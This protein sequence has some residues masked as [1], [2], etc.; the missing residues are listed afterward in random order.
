MDPTKLGDG[1]A[2]LSQDILGYL[3]F[4]AGA[5]DARFLKNLGDLFGR[6]AAACVA[7]E[8]AWKALAERLR[9]ELRSV[10]GTVEA[11]R[12][13]EQAEAVLHLV[14]DLALPAYREHHCD[15]L[16]HQSEEGLFQPLWIGRMCEAV[17]QQ[18]GPWQ[19]SDRI[20][21]AAI[22]QLNDY[23]GHRPVA[24]L[25]TEQKIQPYEHE[26]VR[27][28]PLWIRG[29]GAA[30]GP[31]RELVETAVAIL[32]ATD[33]NLLFESL[34]ALEELDELAF[35]PRAY[36][37]DSPVNKRPNYIFGQWD[38]HTLDNAGHCRRFVLQQVTLD[39]MLDRLAEHGQLDHQQVLF[40]EAAVLAGTMLMGSGVSGNRPDAHDSTVTLATLIEKIAR[41]R[42]AF[43]A[44]LLERMSDRHAERLRAEA[45]ALRQPFGGARQHFNHFLAQRRAQQLQHVHVAQVFAAIGFTAAAA[46]HVAVVPVASARMTCEM[47]C[48]L[49]AAHL[50]VEHEKLAEAAMHLPIIEKLLYTAI[51]C[52]AMVDPWNILGFGGQYSLFPAIENSIHDHRVDELLDMMGDIFMLSVRIHRAAA[53]GGHNEL[54]TSLSEGL[55]ALATWWDKFAAGELD[56]VEGISGQATLES[57]ENVAVALRAWHE[58]GAA[59]GDVAF[60]REHVEQFRTPKAYA[61]V[62]ETLLD[63]RDPVA[64]MALLVQWL[65]QAEEIPLVE[66]DYS[67]HDL[68]LL[69]MEDLWENDPSMSAE[70]RQRKSMKRPSRSAGPAD[71]SPS[72]SEAKSRPSQ[73]TVSQRWPLARKFLDYL[74]AN[75]EE[76]WQVP[77]FDMAAEVLGDGRRDDD[78]TE[79]GGKKGPDDNQEDDRED[80]LFGAAYEHV[81]YRDSTDDGIDS[82]LFEGGG[83]NATDLELVGEGERIVNRLS[84]LTAVAQLWKLSATAALAGNVVDR[85]DVLAAWLDQAVRNHRQLLELL[86]SVAGY[87]ISPP[88]GTH[89]SL[90]DYDRRRSV[91][92]ALLEE[93]I[94]GCVETGDAAQMIR[95][96]MA[97]PPKAADGATWERRAG[98][99]LAAMLRGDAAK[100]HRTLPRLLATLAKEPLLYVALGR[101]GDPRRIAASR[102]LQTMLRRLLSYLPRLGL[103]TETCQL[104]ETAQ[105]MEVDHPVGPGAI[106]EFDRIFEIGCRGITQ[107][108][109]ASS[110]KWPPGGK[111]PAGKKGR[112]AMISPARKS[113]FAAARG[114]TWAD[115]ERSH[116]Q[117]IGYL[118]QVVEVLLRYWLMHSHGVRLS[119]LESVADAQRW[120]RLKEFIERYGSDLFTQRFMNLGNLRGILHEGT[121]EYLQSL[122]DEPEPD[123][124]YHLLTELNTA[125]PLEEA[126]YW[127]GITIEAVV[128]NYGE[129]IDYNSITTQSDRGDMLY[130]LLDFLRLRANYDRLAWN[131]RP[132]VLAHQVLV[133]RGCEGAARIWRDAVAERTAPIAEEHL[134]RLQRLSKKYGMR[135]PSIVEHLGERFVRPLEIDQLCALLRPAVEE[136]RH[137]RPADKL[138]QLEAQVA[139]FTKEPPGA[140][141]EVPGWLDALEQEMEHGPWDVGEGEEEDDDLPPDA[142]VF[143]PQRLLAPE[144]VEEQIHQML[145][146]IADLPSDEA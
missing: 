95:A 97:N 98:D 36:D 71:G 70:G 125:I 130:T 3:N 46:R 28:I 111:R 34:F 73:E 48:H 123:E 33:P 27:P 94:E 128:E 37:F 87:R 23:L 11:F 14:F 13:T 54:Q 103:L 90:V 58:G 63:R 2:S 110:A 15:L 29:V 21:P 107:C 138:Q 24:V 39:A 19:E 62:I 12:Q 140:G 134:N 137:D 60:W 102:A 31:Y 89:E 44:R 122:L 42:D 47:R 85:D 83:E 9:A 76:F 5:S 38:M 131:L 78:A 25:Q 67:F 79:A 18:G 53:A 69:W 121:R 8:P 82:E 68:A 139:R 75:A 66:E 22:H 77:R 124:E 117:L 119:V 55:R 57:A 1:V 109:V 88:R 17:L 26:W 61:L 135:L 93:I 113:S 141:F 120:R 20:V 56:S 43:Y 45:T 114:A 86:E 132:V 108:L 32:D 99:V 64:A 92:E 145:T 50:A 65:S 127:L 49:A 74:E 144:E 6:V 129:Y 7:D 10:R 100:V 30:P 142:L 106:T 126:A 91:K 118:E 101:G 133:Q 136:I 16:F 96:S 115:S 35:D 80:D 52:G 72:A 59:A 41:Y 112:K 51:E 84:F 143:V 105:R 104:L 116:G 4:S 146:A 81:T 40:E